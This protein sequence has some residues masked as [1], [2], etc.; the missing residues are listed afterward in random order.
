[1]GAVALTDPTKSGSIAKA[2]ENVIQQQMQKRLY[3]LEASVGEQ[4]DPGQQEAQAVREG[5]GPMACNSC[6]SP[7]PMRATLSTRPQNLLSM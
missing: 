5:W 2:F 1:M 4:I 6:N 7:R 3:A